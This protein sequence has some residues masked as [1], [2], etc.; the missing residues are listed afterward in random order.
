MR[1][2]LGWGLMHKEPRWAKPFGQ[3][4]FINRCLQRSVPLMSIQPAHP[5]A[6]AFGVIVP[7]TCLYPKVPSISFCLDSIWIEQIR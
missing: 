6:D 3:V 1:D 4:T 2:V 5:K 7:L